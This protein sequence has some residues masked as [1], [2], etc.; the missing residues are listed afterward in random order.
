MHIFNS[1]L[2]QQTYDENIKQK[3]DQKS[4]LSRL[5]YQKWVLVNSSTKDIIVPPYKI[6]THVYK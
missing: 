5:S 4:N 1:V 2:H 3:P 6:Q